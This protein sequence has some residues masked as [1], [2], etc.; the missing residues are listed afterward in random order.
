LALNLGGKF[1]LVIIQQARVRVDNNRD[2][3]APRIQH[4]PG[5]SVGQDQS[6]CPWRATIHAGLTED[7]VVAKRV[8]VRKDFDVHA[9]GGLGELHL[10][11]KDIEPGL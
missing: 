8:L 9:V 2:A 5:S 6:L 10:G 3:D 1:V 11:E 4:G 7:H